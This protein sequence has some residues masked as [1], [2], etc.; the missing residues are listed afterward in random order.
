M[1]KDFTN[2]KRIDYRSRRMKL[3][4]DKG[5]KVY[6]HDGVSKAGNAY[7]TYSL[8]VSSKDTKGEWQNAYLDCIFKKGV[9]VNHK[10][11]IKINNAFP[12]VS[13]YNDKT[14]VRWMITDFE[15]VDSGES[16][17]DNGFINIPDSLDEELPFV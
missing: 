10:A 17:S 6:R 2:G 14:T 4:D 8:G 9:E 7:T 3:T 12:T 15:V 1:G 5:V 13:K 16:T 11:K